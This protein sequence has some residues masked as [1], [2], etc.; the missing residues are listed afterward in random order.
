MRRSSLKRTRAPGRRTPLKRR[1]PSGGASPAASD[2]RRAS[3]EQRAKV[4]GQ[5]CLVC[6]RSGVDP[7]HVIPRSLGGCDRPDCVV[8][9]CREHHRAYDTGRLDL[10]SHLEPHWQ[11]E[12]AH[13][14]E[15]A[16]LLGAL[17]R[18]TGRRDAR[19]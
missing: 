12:L 13:A 6:G 8:P 10:L 19:A 18:L 7:A 9:L 2:G 5:A 17:R 14:V 4:A 16:G 1:T 11:R 3:A 15:H